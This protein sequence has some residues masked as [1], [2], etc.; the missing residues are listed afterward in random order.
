MSQVII[1]GSKCKPT[2]QAEPAIS[3]FSQEPAPQGTHQPYWFAARKLGLTFLQQGG[4]KKTSCKAMNK[5]V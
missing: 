3:G 4:K 2:P 1:T 5:S